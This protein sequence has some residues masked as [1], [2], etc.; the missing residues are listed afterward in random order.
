M[1]F[2]IFPRLFSILNEFS[3]S[4][5]GANIKGVNEKKLFLVIID[6]YYFYIDKKYSIMQQLKNK[7]V[8]HYTV[9]IACNKAKPK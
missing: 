7:N 2:F 5:N 4:S 1:F 6:L 8:L 3:K 9:I